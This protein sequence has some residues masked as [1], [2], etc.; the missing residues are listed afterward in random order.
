MSTF[1]WK[2]R[3][4]RRI[5][6]QSKM[7]SYLGCL[8]SRERGHQISVC[9]EK[10][11]DEFFKH[12]Q[13]V[14][15]KHKR[16]RHCVTLWII[17]LSTKPLIHAFTHIFCYFF[18]AVEYQNNGF[19]WWPNFFKY[20][21]VPQ[22]RHVWSSF[23]YFWTTNDTLIYNRGIYSSL[24]TGWNVTRWNTHPHRQSCHTSRF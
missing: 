3:R 1:R 7:K 11:T 16:L 4:S 23:R 19:E 9:F 5:E 6:F 20:L 14:V 13:D 17:L 18:S 12:C 21:L 24:L 15:G 10:Q 2:H 8:V 22:Q